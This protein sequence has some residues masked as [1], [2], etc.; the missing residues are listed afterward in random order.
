[1]LPGAPVLMNHLYETVLLLE[2]KDGMMRSIIQALEVTPSLHSVLILVQVTTPSW[3]GL[4]LNWLAV[5]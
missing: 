3:S 4:T 1:M 2:Y 5:E